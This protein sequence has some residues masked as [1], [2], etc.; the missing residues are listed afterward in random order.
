MGH[1]I[2]K[3]SRPK[4]LAVAAEVVEQRVVGEIANPAALDPYAV[5]VVFVEGWTAAQLI[6]LVE[7]AAAAKSMAVLLFHGVGAE[8]LSV[9]QDAHDALLDH[10]GRNRERLWTGSFVNVMAHVRRQQ[11]ASSR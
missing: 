9:S 10:L 4:A 5:P 3:A 8:H 7:R 2:H 6:A 11:A 1:H